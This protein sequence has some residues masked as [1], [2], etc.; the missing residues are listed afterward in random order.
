MI[1]NDLMLDLLIIVYIIYAAIITYLTIIV[2]PMDFDYDALMTIMIGFPDIFPNP[3]SHNRR[4]KLFS[5]PVIPYGDACSLCIC[6]IDNV[7]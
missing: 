6:T 2:A 5:Q 3:F 7:H 4:P 1:F